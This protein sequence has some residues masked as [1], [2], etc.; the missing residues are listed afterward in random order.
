MDRA[1]W[2]ASGP[3]VPTAL[4]P[5]LPHV[6]PHLLKPLPHGPGKEPQDSQQGTL[7]PG[8]QQGAQFLRVNICSFPKWGA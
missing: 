3:G 5:W 8:E 6:H 7:Y 4:P 2:E 1:S